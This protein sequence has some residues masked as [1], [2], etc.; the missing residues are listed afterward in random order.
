MKEN[1]LSLSSSS[2]SSS[3]CSVHL[4]P[5]HLP[6]SPTTHLLLLLLLLLPIPRFIPLCC[7]VSSSFFSSSASYRFVRGETELVPRQPRTGSLPTCPY[8]S[9]A[10]VSQFRKKGVKIN[11]LLLSLF[12]GLLAGLPACLPV[13]VQPVRYQRGGRKGRINANAT[14]IHFYSPSLASLCLPSI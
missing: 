3:T 8:N 9:S 6:L 2:S 4:L 1:L 5:L 11:P 12:F 14:I 7:L 13:S 10:A